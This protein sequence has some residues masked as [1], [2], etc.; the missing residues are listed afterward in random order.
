[1]ETI[2]WS[3]SP[4]DT[5]AD[6]NDLDTKLMEDG[7]QYKIL[8]YSIQLQAKETGTKY[9]AKMWSSDKMKRKIGTS[10]WS[11]SKPAERKAL[12]TA[13]AISQSLADSFEL[14]D[15]PN[16]AHDTSVSTPEV[17]SASTSAQGPRSKALV[18]TIESG[19]SQPTRS[20]SAHH[21]SPSQPKG[22]ASTS[23]STSTSIQGPSQ[24]SASRI[25]PK[26][27]QTAERP[28]GVGMPPSDRNARGWT[29]PQ[30]P[31][32]VDEQVAVEELGPLR[33]TGGKL[34]T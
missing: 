15:N 18:R 31:G 16:K 34:K 12:F 26:E 23:T 27:P 7:K 10:V 3:P 24:P 25:M 11:L 14:E 22:L 20:V 30:L 17:A 33:D 29:P 19:P 28:G 21:K 9:W 4:D 13:Q 6:L 8:K 32:K 2:T 5:G 1:M